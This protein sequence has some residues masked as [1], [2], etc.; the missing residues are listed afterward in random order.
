MRYRYHQTKLSY[1][2]LIL[3]IVCFSDH[4]SSYSNL[5]CN[6]ETGAWLGHDGFQWPGSGDFFHLLHHRH[7]DCNYGWPGGHLDWLFG[8]FVANKEDVSKIWGRN[9]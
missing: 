6:I 7:F 3:P 8:T 5:I 9:K 1:H 2:S 4:I